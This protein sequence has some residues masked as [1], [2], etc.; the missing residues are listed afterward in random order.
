MKG[1]CA[2]LFL[3]LTL[4]YS[5]AQS[6]VDSALIDTS[7]NRSALP[8]TADSPI[9]ADAPIICS[10][11]SSPDLLQVQYASSFVFKPTIGL[12]VGMFSFYGDMYA[13]HFQTPM[14]SRLAY[15]LTI[16]QGLTSYLDFDFFVL[17]GKLSAN[18]HF[19]P[20][21]RNLNF[22][23]SIKS[24]GISLT[25]NFDNF[26]PSNHKA[27]PFLSVGFESFE[28][29][30]KTDMYD[31][32]GNKYYYWLD[33]TTRN[34]AEN[35][36]NAIN[37]IEINRDY[38]Y[39]TDIREVL[40][41]KTDGVKRYPEHSFALPVG[42]GVT[43]E[44]NDYLKFKLGATMHFTFTDYID[45]VTSSSVGNR[46]GNSKNDNFMITSFSIHYNL[47]S[48]KKEE[49]SIEE[50]T[51]Y[52]NVDFLAIDAN[53]QDK[54]GVTDDKDSC[55]G[56]P[57]G[58]AV[59]SHGCALDDDGDGVP[60]YKDSE[61]NSPKSA[62][63]DSKGVQMNDSTIAYQYNVYNDSIG[64]F[65]KVEMY[66]KKG[67]EFVNPNQ[68]EYMVE[69]GRFKSG[70]TP[71][72]MTKFLSIN[73][74]SSSSIDD[75]TTIYKAGSYVSSLDAEKR[76]QECISQGFADAKVIYLKNGKYYDAT[77]NNAT[78]S[79]A[80]IVSATSSDIKTTNPTIKTETPKT[81]MDNQ[82]LVFR[83][84][85]GAFHRRLSKNVFKGFKDLIEVKTDDGLYK[86]MTGSFKILDDAAKQKVEILLNGY[87]GAFITAY[88]NGKRITLTEAGATSA[89][90]TDSI[91]DTK[92]SSVTNSV[93]KELIKFKIQVGIFKN[94]PP[95]DKAEIFAKIKGLVKEST[96]NGLTK[97]FVGSTDNYS[98]AIAFKNDLVK[99]FG[100]TDA[101]I[102]AF[103]NNQAI[104]VQEALELLK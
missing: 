88:K 26:L 102:V 95:S 8:H 10:Y 41:V 98:E 15:Q 28:F 52:D 56:T 29:L 23:S 47:G 24:G 101:F 66:N 63:V 43:F 9:I 25:Y 92:D 39:E 27:N 14:V 30:S 37:A 36:V 76:K 5:F 68:K 16:T 72:I 103:F 11:I 20:N 82:A 40:N 85:L 71:E 81:A 58:V 99:N 3:F 31:K 22:E 44:I 34:M 70:L 80:T 86:Y 54:D 90:K 12:G 45:G 59:N 7:K 60:N 53:D 73:D 78:D 67:S 21:N 64:A 55:Q 77:V 89:E 97:Y 1:L 75:S 51:L 74:I 94:L 48:K 57:L 18:E 49:S 65:A 79:K 42:A 87:E 104:S 46:V 61:I 17:Y 91:T 6:K 13:K 84:Q 50:N 83:I 93:N 32:Y 4:S 19:S 100:L 2:F 33:G 62:I 38:T 96:A 69:L 35:D